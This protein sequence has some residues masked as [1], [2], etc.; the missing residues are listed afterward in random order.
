MISDF[1]SGRRLGGRFV[2]EREVGRGGAGVVFRAYDQVSQGLVALKV[3]QAEAGDVPEEEERL[4]REGELL[5]ELKHPG[6]VR[7]VASG[8]LDETGQPYVAMEWLEG[9]DVSARQRRS[10]LSLR[11]SVEL[12]ASVS[13][14]LVAAHDL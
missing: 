3:L 10:P 13:D 9:E 11:Q 7:M 6:I 12:V 2:I 5:A 14:A 8:V 4:R 1:E